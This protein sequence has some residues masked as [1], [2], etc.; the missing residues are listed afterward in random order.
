[1]HDDQ[2]TALA[3]STD[4]EILV[5]GD[6]KGN[7][8]WWSLTTGGLLLHQDGA[9]AV[10]AIACTQSGALIAAAGLGSGRPTVGV[11]DVRRR[12]RL[13]ILREAA[14]KCTAMAFSISG[15]L[16]AIVTTDHD[17]SPWSIQSKK[18][19]FKVSARAAANSQSWGQDAHAPSQQALWW[20]ADDASFTQITLSGAVTKV[21]ATTGSILQQTSAGALH[22]VAAGTDGI[23]A[24]F[25]ARDSRLA[26]IAANGTLE[27]Q[28]A[29]EAHVLAITGNSDMSSIALVLANHQLIRSGDTHQAQIATA[30][31][32]VRPARRAFA[33]SHKERIVWSTGRAVYCADR[34]SDT[35][36]T[37]GHTDCVRNVVWLDRRYLF[38][39][40]ADQ[41]LVLWDTLDSKIVFSL[42]LACGPITTI[43]LSPQRTTLCV[44][45]TDG[46]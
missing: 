37:Q 5:V 2:I 16:L 41:R 17:I 9:C 13:F 39:A 19:L 22:A 45:D 8:R 46:A 24:I 21:C 44:A 23:S 6:Y 3:L 40:G 11:Y 20:S 15:H 34:D 38:S 27:Y 30:P 26:R 18:L 32:A 33:S 43:A 14:D 35:G 7:L 10:T 1:V 28:P 4:G 29:A 42:Q 36:P 31:E 25:Y 12:K